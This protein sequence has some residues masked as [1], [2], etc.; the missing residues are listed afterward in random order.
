MGHSG[1]ADRTPDL[2]GRDGALA[3]LRSALADTTERV[4]VVH[5][6]GARGSGRTAMLQ[7]V[8]RQG[9]QRATVVWCRGGV[10]VENPVIS[11]PPTGRCL[12]LVDDADALAADTAAALRNVVYRAQDTNA[13]EPLTL[14][15]AGPVDAGTPLAAVLG[16][17][18]T[19]RVELDPLAGLDAFA[20]VR[21]TLG[22]PVS[23]LL[24]DELVAISGGL[25]A[26]LIGAA[27]AALQHGLL[28]V[29]PDG[30]SAAAPLPRSLASSTADPASVRRLDKIGEASRRLMEVASCIGP[31]GPVAALD[32]AHDPSAAELDDL[33]DELA[34]AQVIDEDGS[35][36]WF[37][38][39]E[40]AH[41]AYSALPSRTR[42]QL[43]AT[44][45]R[46]LLDVPGIDAQ[47]VFTQARLA[48]P[49]VDART[50]LGACEHAAREAAAAGR[51]GAAAQALAT[52]SGVTSL[53]APDRL[54]LL[55]RWADALHR[56]DAGADAC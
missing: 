53:P 26:R 20:L 15:V 50:R 48:G 34:A 18:A 43:H 39:P 27:R 36:F 32:A 19:V 4:T 38:D 54:D 13:T 52:A 2:V 23:P 6:D 17:A 10:D 30:L 7:W 41:W 11:A 44:I 16:D 56:N 51:W 47:L 45:A 8:A 24:A 12:V 33:L 42:Q 3:L 22:A 35:R 37:D 14:V 29:G 5:V 31:S 49:K 28:H 1:A 21:A 25:P 46:R 40:L 9:S 55:M